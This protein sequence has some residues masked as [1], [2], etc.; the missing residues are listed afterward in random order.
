MIAFCPLL[1]EPKL[2]AQDLAGSML[3]KSGSLPS[4][5]WQ[6]NSYY[7]A[8]LPQD[9]RQNIGRLQEATGPSASRRPLKD[10]GTEVRI[11]AVGAW[12]KGHDTSSFTRCH[13]NVSL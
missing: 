3:V 13:S 7:W 2:A 11:G 12:G 5:Q 1:F 8:S 4:Q 6:G 9:G 10:R